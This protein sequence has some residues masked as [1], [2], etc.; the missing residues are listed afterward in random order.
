LAAVVAV[1]A[2]L[3]AVLGL[4]RHWRFGTGYDLAI[5][6][7]VVWHLSRFEIPASTITGHT[8]I[9]GDHF[10]PIIAL[11]APLYWFAPAPETLI[12]A[13]AILLS[14]SIV[15]VFYFI[16]DR[17]PERAALALSVAYGLFWGMQRIAVTDVH[18]LAFAPLLIA[19]GILAIDRQRWRLL[20]TVAAMLVVVKE[21]MIPVVAAFGALVALR[22]P[23][24]MQ[25]ALMA[26]F[27]L[28]LFWAVVQIVIPWFNNGAPWTTGGAFEAFWQRPWTAPVLLVTPPAK[29]RTIVIW[30]APFVFLPLRSPYGW[31]L[32]PIAAER[33]LSAVP[34]HYG[35]GAHYSAPLAPIL[36]MSA[37]DGLARLAASVSPETRG[38][39]ITSFAAATVVI[40][41]VVP[42]HQPHWRLFR[43]RQ[44]QPPSATAA[45]TQALSLI[46]PL[47]SVVAQATLAPHLSHR[48]EIPIL[49][50]GSPDADYVI[51]APDL[52]PWP[53]TRDEL[54][55]LLLERRQRG[56]VP[57][58]DEN[59]W[60]VLR[61]LRITQAAGGR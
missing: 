26:A 36:A 42:G 20:W 10:H 14:A 25:G 13:Q 9:F 37:A 52:D 29:L 39:V 12:V 49:Q 7:Q 6:D 31:L 28:I 27:A 38:R 17:L 44:D 40:A 34:F 60:I 53:V 41:S 51:A 15:P 2:T 23:R 18:E 47:A 50:P 24:R 5:F 8:N 54:V 43:A 1:F 32:V 11:F 45:A 48:A 4:S 46:P 61:N 33:L 22:G 21:D 19:T 3:Y 56:Y 35:G 16:R 58:F 55:G 30:L 57:M 59:G